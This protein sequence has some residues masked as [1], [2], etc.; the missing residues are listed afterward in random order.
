M[1]NNYDV[2]IR[3]IKVD[4]ITPDDYKRGLTIAKLILDNTKLQDRDFDD[5]I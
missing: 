3:A 2:K 4:P 5:N 1:K